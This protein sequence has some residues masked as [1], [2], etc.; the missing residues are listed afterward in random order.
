MPTRAPTR[1]RWRNTPTKIPTSSPS[2]GA[3]LPTAPSPTTTTPSPT[4]SPTKWIH[5]LMCRLKLKLRGTPRIRSDCLEVLRRYLSE[6]TGVKGTIAR[7]SSDED[8]YHRN[9]Q[10]SDAPLP[11]SLFPSPAPTSSPSLA[12][13]SSP[14]DTSNEEIL[15]V[16]SSRPCMQALEASDFM[17]RDI[18]LPNVQLSVV[19]SIMEEIISGA[20]EL[21]TTDGVPVRDL[22]CGGKMLETMD[23]TEP[24]PP[25]D[26]TPNTPVNDGAVSPVNDGAVSPG[27]NAGV[28][29][30]DNAAP[31]YAPKPNTAAFAEPPKK[32]RT[33]RIIIV[34]C[35]LAF[36]FLL[37]VLIAIYYCR[38]R[39][40]DSS[41]SG[42]RSVSRGSNGSP[43]NFRTDSTPPTA[44]GV[45]VGPYGDSGG[46]LGTDEAG[47]FMITA[48]FPV[49]NEPEEFA[50]E[51]EPFFDALP[52]ISEQAS[53]NHV[54][55]EA[56]ST[57]MEHSQN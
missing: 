20:V 44:A 41:A 24:D 38:R 16:N 4:R 56:G 37:C 14:T 10:Q 13:T 39:R 43:I 26:S 33:K 28:S 15:V 45:I 57:N 35:T 42:G 48:L 51:E 47:N 3:P 50:A 49:E 5:K 27:D 53:T 23:S 18:K 6:R 32:A 19:K 52:Y 30:G 29:P 9:L 12:P 31:D 55:T 1:W 7:S 46:Q 21:N 25:G 54:V 8:I 36:I 17:D 40:R 2:G 34:C 11:L 22:I